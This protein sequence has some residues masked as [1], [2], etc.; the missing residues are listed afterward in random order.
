MSSDRSSLTLSQDVLDDVIA[1][2]EFDSP[3]P[4]QIQ[5]VEFFPSFLMGMLIYEEHFRSVWVNDDSNRMGKQPIRLAIFHEPP[6]GLLE[7]VPNSFEV[8]DLCP[9]HRRRIILDL[10]LP[11]RS[12]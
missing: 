8:L 7:S 6:Q 9:H 1:P 5:K 2:G 3:L 11:L 12:V 4:S 10:L